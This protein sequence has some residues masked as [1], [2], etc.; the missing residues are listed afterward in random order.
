MDSVTGCAMS[1]VKGEVLSYMLKNPGSWHTTWHLRHKF[2][3]ESSAPM[4][5]ILKGL[6]FRGL[7]EADRRLTNNTKWRIKN[8]SEAAR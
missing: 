1:D 6:E 7:I 2:K 8:G 5:A 4:R 3:F